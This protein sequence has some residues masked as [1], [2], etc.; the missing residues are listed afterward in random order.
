MTNSPPT[1]LLVTKVEARKKISTQ[2]KEGRTILRSVSVSI[3]PHEL[4]PSFPKTFE[5][6]REDQEKWSKYTIQLLKSMFSDASIAREFGHWQI[7]LSHDEDIIEMFGNG[8]K[9]KIRSLESI[10]QRVDLF[11]IAKAN[12]AAIVAPVRPKQLSRDIF[13][14]HGHDEAAQQAVARVIDKLSLRALILH[15]QP[16]KSRTVIEK[17]EHHSDVGFAVVLLTPD[18]MGHPKGNPAEAKLRARQ[19]VVFELGYF[20]GRL[21]RSKVCALLKGD[22][23]IPSDYSGI[24]YTPMDEAGAWRYKLAKEIKGAG[25]DVDLNKLT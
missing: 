7:P 23:E 16:D 14:V 11:P 13:I 15:E 4:D 24:L 22:I 1:S 17:F 25:I 9:D 18:D 20:I 10:D 8:V 21:G 12:Q 2:I 3:I 6:A 19:N 5:K